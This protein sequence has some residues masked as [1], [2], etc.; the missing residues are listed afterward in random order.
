MSTAEANPALITPGEP[1]GIGPDLALMAYLDDPH[2]NNVVVADPDVMMQRARQLNLEVTCNDWVAH[3]FRQ[4]QLNLLPVTCPC[5]VTPGQP[6][7]ASAGYVL[8]TLQAAVDRCLDGTAS[9]LVTGPV[10]KA[11]INDAGVPFSG[12][13]EWLADACGVERVVMMLASPALKVALATTHLPLRQVA[14]AITLASL[15]RTIRILIDDLQSRFAIARPRII[16]CGLNP[17]AG[18]GGHLG[19]EEIDVIIPA[20]ASIC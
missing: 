17:H 16:V 9:A 7:T 1:A 20:L 4:G 19:N 12:H 13:T 2:A 15:Q 5:R 3:G 18:E 8:Q 14:D 10:N 11:V 6:Q